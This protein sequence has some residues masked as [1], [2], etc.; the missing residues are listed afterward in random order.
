LR[1]VESPLHRLGE[2]DGSL[3]P[4]DDGHVEMVLEVKGHVGGEG[5]GLPAIGAKDAA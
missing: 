4:G 3:G 5:V 1:L 2:A